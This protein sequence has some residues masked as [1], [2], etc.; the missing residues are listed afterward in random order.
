MLVAGPKKSFVPFKI[1]NSTLIISH[2]LLVNRIYN[3]TVHMV[4][5]WLVK[6]L[7]VVNFNLLK[8]CL[9]IDT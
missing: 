3:G 2:H 1:F 4:G 5:F 6:L 7:R 9:L 8:V